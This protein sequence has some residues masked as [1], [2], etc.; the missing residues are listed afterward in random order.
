MVRFLLN[1]LEA[2]GRREE[3]FT[4]LIRMSPQDLISR[5]NCYLDYRW[6]SAALR[7]SENLQG[8]EKP[9]PLALS[10]FCLVV[11]RLPVYLIDSWSASVFKHE[12]R[13]G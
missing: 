1:H 9:S 2:G 12:I 11:R 6:L 7:L 13:Y 3:A 5:G 4:M 10:A 8:A